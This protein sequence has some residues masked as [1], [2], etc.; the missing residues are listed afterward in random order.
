MPKLSSVLKA[1]QKMVKFYLGGV[2]DMSKECVAVQESV[3]N[4]C[5]ISLG[6]K[7]SGVLLEG[8]L[9]FVQ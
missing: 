1:R 9:F 2:A 6:Q 7:N 5:A 4:D 8:T 3:N